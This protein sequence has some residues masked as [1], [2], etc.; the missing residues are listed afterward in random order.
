MK[1]RELSVMS[2][3]E[4]LAVYWAEYRGKMERMYLVIAR[5]WDDGATALAESECEVTDSSLDGFSLIK[6]ESQFDMLVLR[7]V[8]KDNLL[9][10]MIDHS[11]DAMAE[12]RKR[13]QAG[14][15]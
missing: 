15:S 5:E 4:V 14:S 3:S 1:V 6:N 2:E 13:R 12:Y 7:T 10:R 9:D 11:S 8:V